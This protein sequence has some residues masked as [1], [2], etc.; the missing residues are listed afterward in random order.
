MS[1][2]K[3]NMIIATTNVECHLNNKHKQTALGYSNN[4][5]SRLKGPRRANIDKEK[6]VVLAVLSLQTAVFFPVN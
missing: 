3:Q 1:V 2:I 6:H 5:Y 4:N